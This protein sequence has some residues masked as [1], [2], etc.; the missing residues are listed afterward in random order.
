MMLFL[1]YGTICE[2]FRRR[3]DGKEEKQHAESSACLCFQCGIEEE[4][5]RGEKEKGIGM[6]WRKVT[7]IILVVA[8]MGLILYDFIPFLDP[9]R[10]DTISEVIMYYALRLFTLPFGFGVLCGHFF[11]PWDDHYP[12]PKILI[13]VAVLLLVLDVAAHTCS[14]GFLLTVQSYP[15]IWFVSGVPFGHCF[16]PQQRE[17]K[18]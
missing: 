7:K 3:S 2:V 9:T 4:G 1:V 13:P 11:W 16:W 8:A 12:Q 5:G 15:I 14:I 10:G 17:D 6:N 18:L